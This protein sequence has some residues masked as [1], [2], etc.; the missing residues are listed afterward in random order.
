M[1][2]YVT[3]SA[4]DAGHLTLPE[5]LF[6]TDADP[7]R[8]TTVPSLSFLI[9]HPS[10]PPG[11]PSATQTNI[12]FD[13]GIKRDLTGYTPAQQA[14]IAQRQPII[15]S[16]DCADSLRRGGLDPAHDIDLTLL[17]HI[18]W[19]H[20]GTPS[21]FPAST[22]LVGSGTLSMLHHG[23][24]PLYPAELFNPS[25]LPPS[26]TIELPPS[27]TSIP[28]TP[29]HTPT[30]LDTKA[31]L[32]PFRS[33][34]EWTPLPGSTT[35]N[36]IDIFADASLYLIDSPGHLPGHINLVARTAEKKYVYLG[37][38]CC[39]DARI[40]TGDKGIALYSDGKGGLRSVHVDTE[41]ARGTLE[42]M[43]AWVEGREREGWEVEMV[44]AHDAGWR[45]GNGGRFW[46]GC[47]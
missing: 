34:W 22:F 20:I 4:L 46:P 13:L 29:S 28:H 18:H 33:T 41:A 26:R 21:D 37:G 40:W 15:T 8:N 27:L 32:P 25:E 10:P 12:V 5:R 1:S 16:P 24:G 38:D 23:A 19:D 47:L 31:K 44:L 35:L 42:G 6:V 30:P 9:Q 14:H 43:R 2:V 36:A 45:E 3:V 11:R 39:H 7:E 17:S